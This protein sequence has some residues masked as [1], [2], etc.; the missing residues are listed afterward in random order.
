MTVFEALRRYERNECTFVDMR[1]FNGQV[2][3]GRAK[4]KGPIADFLLSHDTLM[5]WSGFSL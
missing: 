4:L 1:K 3:K 2:L 5:A